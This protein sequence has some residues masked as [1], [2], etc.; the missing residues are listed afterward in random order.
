M[1]F[2][3]PSL[4][5]ANVCAGDVPGQPVLMFTLQGTFD[6]VTRVVKL[7]KEYQRPVPEE[8]RVAYEGTL[9][10]PVSAGGRPTLAGRWRNEI[11]GSYGR[12]HCVLQD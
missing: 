12:F 1:L 7:L 9:T 4:T 2:P 5:F 11:E 10:W 6:P 3:K 8:L